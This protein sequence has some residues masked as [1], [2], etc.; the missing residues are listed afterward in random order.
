V[1]EAGKA[2]YDIPMYANTWLYGYGR[3]NNPGST[4]SGGPLPHVHDLWRAGAPSIDILS[5]DLYNDFEPFAALYTRFGNPLFVPEGQSGAE[6]ASRALSAFLRH[7]AI[8][9]S[10][11]GIESGGPGG[12]RRGAQSTN[13]A[14]PPDP[15]AQTYAILAYLAPVILDNQGKGAIV[16]LQATNDASAAPQQLKLGDYTLNITYGAG[17][18]VGPGGNVGAGG[19]RRGGGRRGGA[20]GG[21]GGGGAGAGS[22]SGGVV[23]TSP[24]RFV[25]NSGPGEYWFV[26]GPMSVTFTPNSPERGSV[27]MGSFD[28]TLNVNG[29]WEA[30]RRLN[31]DET[32]NNTRWPVMGSYGIYRYSVFQRQ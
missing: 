10:A 1:A 27:V 25:I 13:G 31:G 24:A 4:P 22:G 15:F 30:G 7:D 19:G 23:N 6:G 14:P 8:G 12:G 32:G 29:R 16:M 3:P 9:Y 18:S 21:G 5:P 17:G 26:G 28:E 11:F 2:E 20:G